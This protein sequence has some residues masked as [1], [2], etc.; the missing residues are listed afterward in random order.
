GTALGDTELMW[1]SFKTNLTGIIL[2]FGISLLIGLF[3]PMQQLSDELLARTDVGL[4]GIV[5]ALASGA[6]A[7]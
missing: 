4:A 1:R 5:L 3:W 7:V 6:A 2:A